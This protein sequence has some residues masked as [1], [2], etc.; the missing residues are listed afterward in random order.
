MYKIITLMIVGFLTACAS[1][2]PKQFAATSANQNI[3]SGNKD[4]V[5][6]KTTYLDTIKIMDEPLLTWKDEHGHI[7]QV[8]YSN[9]PIGYKTFLIKY[10]NNGIVSSI[11]Q[12]MNEKYFKHVS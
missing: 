6:G 12:T 4:I 7:Y 8:A 3:S 5:V 10:D 11:S 1:S 2:Q 9:Q